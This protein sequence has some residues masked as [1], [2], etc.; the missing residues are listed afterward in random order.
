[1]K[2]TGCIAIVFF[3]ALV[4]ASA[5]IKNKGWWQHAVFYQVYPKSFMDSNSDGIG[6]LKGIQEKLQHFVDIGITGI[7]LSPIN[8]SPDKDNGYDISDF[9]D[10][11][12]AFGTL[13][14]F[15]NLV[16]EA[17]TLGLKVIL[18]LVPN[19]T[20]DKHQWFVESEKNNK[21]YKD[22][23]I[24]M[25]K[26]PNNWVSVFNGSAWKYNEQRKQYYYH[27]FY[28]QQPDLN[29][30]NTAV[31][32]EMKEIMQF[33]L[34]KGLDGFRIDAVPHIYESNINQNEPLLSDD[35]NETLHASYNHTL[36]KDQPKTYDLIKSWRE[37]V[38]EYA[39]KKNRDE[40]VLMTEAY[41]S[42]DNTI[43]YYNFGSQVPFNFKYIT[44]ANVNSSATNFKNIA[45]NWISR[46]PPDDV[47][48]WVMGNHDR[49]RVSS[50]YPGR[51]DQ[52]I[53]LEMILPGVAVTYYGEEIGMVDNTD[54]EFSD[55]RDGCRTPMQWNSDAYAGFTKGNKT[56]LPVHKNYKILNVAAEKNDSNSVYNM[57]KNLTTLRKSEILRYGA[58]DT[59]VVQD[60][61]LVVRRRYNNE[62]LALLINFSNDK[63]YTVDLVDIMEKKPSEVKLSDTISKVPRT[64]VDLNA[65]SIPAKAS[66][67]LVGNLAN[68]AGIS[69]VSVLL[70]AIV[71]LYRS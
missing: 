11:Q 70:A 17:K 55:F 60:N 27:Q 42:L 48:N 31:Q 30:D 2:S 15:E 62:V 19:H 57:Y 35:L 40:V 52:M 14:D 38:D 18:D 7:W 21:T 56:W 39:N 22:Y 63:N 10:I 32:N 67:V 20:S 59:R 28:W 36:T 65:F 43:K 41:T 68:T 47:A 16:K 5:E 4:L 58:V 54:F 64:D 51:G 33:W 53:M 12:P 66:V 44:D 34:D 3:A 9:R 29:Y 49:N 37:F 1:M 61:V 6:D 50:R 24:W 45:D 71:S 46:I 13:Q 26:I 23:Y 25:D 69:L 8:K